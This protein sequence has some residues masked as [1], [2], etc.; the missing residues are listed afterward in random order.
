M[1][2]MTQYMLKFSKVV[3]QRTPADERKVKLRVPI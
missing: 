1:L 2:K 3:G